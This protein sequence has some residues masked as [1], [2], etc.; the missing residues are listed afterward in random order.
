[1]TKQDVA[2]ILFAMLLLGEDPGPGLLPGATLILLAIVIGQVK[3][4]ALPRISTAWIRKPAY[5]RVAA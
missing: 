5:A 1:M 2:G 3:L 4:P